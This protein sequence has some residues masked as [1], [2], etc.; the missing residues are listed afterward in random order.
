VFAFF[1]LFGGDTMKRIETIFEVLM[2]RNIDYFMYQGQ[3]FSLV[4]LVTDQDKF[5]DMPALGEI[6]EITEQEFLHYEE[7]TMACKA[8]KSDKERDDLRAKMREFKRG[9]KM[10][11][12]KEQNK[13]KKYLE[14]DGCHSIVFMD[15]GNEVKYQHPSG[16][17]IYRSS[18]EM[19]SIIDAVT[20]AKTRAGVK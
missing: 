9:N 16:L 12:K 15:G 11:T 17:K 7:L 6:K 20:E 10:T 2:E 18:S 14:N 3:C 13:I 8:A 4:D 19:L 1:Q 5:R